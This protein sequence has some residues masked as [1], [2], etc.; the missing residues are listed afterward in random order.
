MPRL[1]KPYVIHQPAG[2]NYRWQVNRGS[3]FVDVSGSLYLNPSPNQ[4]YF[5]SIPDSLYGY[6]YRCLVDGQ[7]GFLYNIQFANYW[8]GDV[9]N[10]WETPANWTCGTVPGIHTDV[11]IKTGTVIV[12]SNITCR[13]IKVSQGATLIIDPGFTITLT[14]P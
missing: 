12:N 13:S 9:S 8:K 5:Y 1:S 4:L 10:S 2:T 6:Q 14:G 3:G 7:S 11:F